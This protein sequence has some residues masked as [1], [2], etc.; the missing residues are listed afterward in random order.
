V[1]SQ[2][3]V[4]PLSIHTLMANAIKIIFAEDKPEFRKLMIDGLA[5]FGVECIAEANNGAELLALGNLKKAD[6]ILLDLE[7]PVMDGNETMTELMRI[8]PQANVLII[9]FHSETILVDD[10]LKRGAKGYVCKDTA[11]GN[12]QLLADGLRRIKDGSTF[13]YHKPLIARNTFTSRQVEMIPLICD[14]RTNKEIASEMGITE[15]SVERQRQKIYE[16]AGAS[17]TASF[18]KFAF[19]RGL[20]FLGRKI[21]LK[22]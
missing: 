22:G 9:S 15:R 1:V 7:M 21:S 17:G 12:L 18:L 6:V 19:R 3:F 11:C 2:I 14:E 20:D 13:V 8:Y 5:D 4:T 10:Y 16:K